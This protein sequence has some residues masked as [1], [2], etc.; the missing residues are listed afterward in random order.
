M[1]SSPVFPIKL[2]T[3]HH[4]YFLNQLRMSSARRSLYFD[5]RITVKTKAL[6]SLL[7]SLNVL[8]RFH[9]IND[10]TYRVFPSYT[11][12]RRHTRTFK[13]YTRINGRIRMQKKALRLLNF[14]APHTYYVIETSRGLITHKEAIRLGIGGSLLMIIY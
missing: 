9:K 12:Y 13:T 1:G 4:S 6:A 11:R 3:N 8:R 14:L 10:L 5:V 7:V 2:I